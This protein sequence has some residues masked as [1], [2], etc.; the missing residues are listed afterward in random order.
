MSFTQHDISRLIE[1]LPQSKQNA[2]HA[3]DIAQRL[4]LPIS[5]NQVEARQLIRLSIQSGNCIV[6]N[7]KRGYWL[8]TN[9]AEIQKYIQSLEKRG[10]DT[11]RRGSELKT[12]WN[13][14]SPDNTI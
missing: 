6:S 11:I 2:I 8:T 13:T 9:K 12:A 5:G 7:T 10:K 14:T 4:G 1:I 3:A